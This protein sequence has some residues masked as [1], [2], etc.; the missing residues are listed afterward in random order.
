MAGSSSPSRGSPLSKLLQLSSE[1]DDVHEVDRLLNIFRDDRMVSL[2]KRAAAEERYQ[3]AMREL[4]DLEDIDK[5]LGRIE[6]DRADADHNLMRHLATSFRGSLDSFG[7]DDDDDDDDDDNDEDAADAPL[8]AITT[9]CISLGSWPSLLA[10][11]YGCF[12]IPPNWRHPN[13]HKGL[14][15]QFFF[16]SAC[17]SN[18]H[19]RNA[20]SAP[21]PT[22][23]LILPPMSTSMLLLPVLLLLL[24]GACEVAPL[25]LPLL[26]L[27]LL[28]LLLLLPLIASNGCWCSG[29]SS[30]FTRRVLL[31]TDPPPPPSFACISAQDR[32]HKQ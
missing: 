1:R 31:R 21:V 30:F 7:D 32:V 9:R 4:S 24:L 19:A 29:C 11:G 15:L 23:P 5:E 27:L 18:V 3:L 12:Q 17:S 2:N 8:Q 6:S 25:P 22:A 20:A 16:F 28:L 13:K 14:T 26:V 10:N